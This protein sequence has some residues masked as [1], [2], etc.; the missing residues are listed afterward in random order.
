MNSFGAKIL[1]V[2][3]E[4]PMSDYK[5]WVKGVGSAIARPQWF[6]VTE[7]KHPDNLIP[8]MQDPKYRSHLV[9]VDSVN[10]V[11]GM[12]RAANVEGIVERLRAVLSVMGAHMIMIGQANQDGSAKGGTKL[13]HHADIT[14]E[15]SPWI[16][17][18]RSKQLWEHLVIPGGFL[19]YVKKNRYGSANQ[20]VLLQHVDGDVIVPIIRLE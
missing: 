19:F 2:Q 5:Q 14:I 11:V 17:K 20:S 15:M 8:I 18:P 1:V 6:H 10:M 12:D 9:I 4:A 3:G 16:P 7:E 13:P